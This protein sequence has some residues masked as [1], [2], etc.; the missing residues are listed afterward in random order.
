MTDESQLGALD[1]KITDEFSGYTVRKDLVS[2]VRGNALVPSYVLEYLLSK[3]ATTTDSAT[4]E[5]G[6]GRVRKI[7]SE[8][9]VH[10]EE[11]N[12]IQSKIREKGRYQVIDK[13]QVALNEKLD[14]YEATFENLGI[15]RVVVDAQTVKDNPKLL[16]TGIWCMCMLVYAYSGEKDEVPWRLHRL[17]PVQMSYDDRENYVAV[18]SH[19]TDSEWI[20]LL[21]QSIGFNP[22][23][24]SER[25]KMLHLVRMIPFVER[26][27]NLVELGP[28]GTGKSHIYSEFSPHGMLIS[29]GEVTVAKLFVN[30]ANG[31]MGLVGYW[32]TVAFDEFAGR[33]KK[34]GKDLVD[35]MKNYMANKSFSRGNNVLHGEASMVF[36]GN[37]SHNVPYMLKNSDLFEELPAQYHDP[38]FLD[39]IHC[40]LP[41]WEFE[42]IRSEMF[43]RGYGFVV[44][45]LAEILH[46][47]RNE[48]YGTAY[49]KYFTL[50][51]SIST[52]DKDG[53]DK[54]FSGLMK[55][56]Y[57]DG[58]A[59]AEQMEPLLRCAIEGRKRVKDQLCRIDSTMVEVD[60]SYTRVGSDQPIAV[61]TLEEDD[62]P[63]LY[64]RGGSAA[65]ET[66]F[67][68]LG[69]QPENVNAATH[70]VGV[71]AEPQKTS[72]ITD[73]LV[74]SDMSE[75][76]SAAIQNG[77]GEGE[78]DTA[79]VRRAEN[80][81]T[82][83]PEQSE[84]TQ[85]VKTLSPL[86]RAAAAA[87][88]GHW[89]FKES[90]RNVT[91]DKLFG[92]HLAG[93]T[94]I[95]LK[96]QYIR[97]PYQMRNLAEFLETVFNFSDHT[98]E[99]HV[100]LITGHSDEQHVD[101]QIDQLTEIQTN[102]APFGIMLTWEFDDSGHDR[103]IV[104]DTGWRI[105][106]GRGLDIFQPIADRDWFNPLIRQQ[107]L[108]RV[109]NFEITY[110]RK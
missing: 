32:D 83:S 46:N 8:N 55:L 50:S 18:R 4:I 91:Y 12:L 29:G 71:A 17:M 15:S 56:L 90:Q 78:S 75:R 102:F 76:K 10:R 43:T 63:E 59:T 44:D 99:I 33:A 62:Y 105:I 61:H 92:C 25:A 88:E 109:K 37:T 69:D 80:S 101:Q 27:Y 65:D 11:A 14:Q 66:E 103:S 84:P 82:A 47:L 22:E 9:Y 16:V 70:E 100:H 97:M 5:S 28:K 34:A 85:P 48:D 87:Q 73:V 42:Q 1:R 81:Q 51:P 19:F 2:E 49:R 41:G 53:V 74:E 60:F 13:V 86:E 64:W 79:E 67:S 104:A 38:A 68:E 45:Y 89:E 77:A 24:F 94:S 108:R 93:A 98:E 3:Y 52:R 21:M 30:N 31:R 107:K 35:I 36:V 72:N 40:Y 95:T 39:R 110:M 57:P 23:L 54:T 96:D 6:V 106:L 7:L 20:N 58:K 26:N